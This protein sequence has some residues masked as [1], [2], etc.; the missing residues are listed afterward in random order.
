MNK[1]QYALMVS[2]VVIA[3]FVGGVI[4]ARTFTARLAA[5][6]TSSGSLKTISAEKFQVVDKKGNIRSVLKQDSLLLFDK[7]GGIRFSLDMD[8]YGD[9]HMSLRDKDGTIRLMLGLDLGGKPYIGLSDDDGEADVKIEVGE[10]GSFVYLS[11]KDPAKGAAALGT[12][13]QGTHLSLSDR[14]GRSRLW[15]TVD[16]QGEP[17]LNLFDQAGKLRAVLGSATLRDV[18]SGINEKIP[19]SSLVLFDKSEKVIW[20]AP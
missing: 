8:I 2:L 15:V 18:R 1:K 3:G 16:P 14:D 7:D 6:D 4:S 20:S 17:S 5:A 10:Q 19:A 13:A 11:G 12:D 9:A